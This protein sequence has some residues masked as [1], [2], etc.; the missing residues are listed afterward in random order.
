MIANIGFG[1]LEILE[2]TILLFIVGVLIDINRGN[3]KDTMEKIV[4]SCIVVLFPLVG[5][6][7]YLS[8]G[9]KDKFLSLVVQKFKNAANG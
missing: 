1:T 5:A 4:W 9:R 3:K 7:V 2:A 8:V 6:I